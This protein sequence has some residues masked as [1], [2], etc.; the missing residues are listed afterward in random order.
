MP[1]R[2][3]TLADAKRIGRIATAELLIDVPDF[4]WHTSAEIT[5]A[6]RNDEYFV[7]T[8][9]GRIIGILCLKRDADTLWIETIAVKRQHQRKGQGKA[10]VR[11]AVERAAQLGLPW[12][13]VSTFSQ[14][15]AEKAYQRMGFH[16]YDQ[17]PENFWLELRVA[18]G[19]P[20]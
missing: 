2:L 19:L 9:K 15:G 7:A 18:D 8:L 12:V 14:Y 5:R 20:Q 4:H 6:I 10:L 11:F 16:V 3:A 1:I 13:R 17:N